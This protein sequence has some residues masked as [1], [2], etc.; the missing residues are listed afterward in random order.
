M[1]SGDS[2]HSMRCA[3]SQINEIYAIPTGSSVDILLNKIL[4]LLGFTLSSTEGL[5]ATYA[6]AFG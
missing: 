1:I 4:L 3:I 2:V 5:T 6:A